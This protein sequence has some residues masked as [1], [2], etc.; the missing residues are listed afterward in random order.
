MMSPYP[1]GLSGRTRRHG[2]TG[3]DLTHTS[4]WCGR[5]TF[6]YS[7]GQSVCVGSQ[8][9]AQGQEHDPRMHMDVRAQLY[10]REER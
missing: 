1:G 6:S 8:F 7:G 9:T 4:T 5:A 3:I 2:R 10:E